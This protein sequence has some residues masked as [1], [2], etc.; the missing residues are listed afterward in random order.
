MYHSVT[1]VCRLYF[2]TL[3]LHGRAEEKKVIQGDEGKPN[4]V[5][6]V[7]KGSEVFCLTVAMFQ[8]VQKG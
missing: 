3:Y 4:L 2:L 1:M 8:T 7:K 6:F 5:L